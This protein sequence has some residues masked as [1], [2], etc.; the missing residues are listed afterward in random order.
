MWRSDLDPYD[1]AGLEESDF[2]ESAVEL[3]L[4]SKDVCDLDATGIALYQHRVL[5]HEPVAFV[6]SQVD[7]G[8]TQGI[9]PMYGGSTDKDRPDTLY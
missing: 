1:Y 6:V 4:L 5:H 2:F 7:V 3:L 9:P 8:F